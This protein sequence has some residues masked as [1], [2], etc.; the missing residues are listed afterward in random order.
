MAMILTTLTLVLTAAVANAASTPAS[1][2]S[3]LHR[4]QATQQVA[5]ACGPPANSQPCACPI[6]NNY[7]TGVLINYFP[8]YQCAYPGGA[9]TWGDKDGVLQNIHQTNCPS[10]AVCP[11]SGCACP[12]DNNGDTGVLI[13]EFTGYQCAYAGGACTWDFDGVLQNTHQTN[14]PTQEKCVAPA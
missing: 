8:G 2:F 10:V 6:D 11:D 3:S 1:P 5:V 12:I 9:C 7:D 4:R 14:C 13:N